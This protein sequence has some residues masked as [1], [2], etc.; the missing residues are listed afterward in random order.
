MGAHKVS[1][2]ERPLVS[3]RVGMLDVH[4]E[5]SRVL[6]SVVELGVTKVAT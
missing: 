5:V 1:L 4:W 6:N 2:T 3:T